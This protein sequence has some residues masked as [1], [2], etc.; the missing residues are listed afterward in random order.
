MTRTERI[1]NKL[2]SSGLVKASEILKEFHEIDEG[3]VYCVCLVPVDGG[4][5]PRSAGTCYSYFDLQ[6]AETKAMPFIKSEGVK[7]VSALKQ[8]GFTK[9]YIQNEEN[10]GSGFYGSLREINGKLYVDLSINIDLDDRSGEDEV[11]K[12]VKSF[13]YK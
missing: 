10:Y 2:M 11:E 9:A 1:A 6:E 3:E 5:F 7:L 4:K 13:G 12:I 8:A